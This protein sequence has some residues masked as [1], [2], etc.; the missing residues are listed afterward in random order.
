MTSFLLI[1]FGYLLGSIPTGVIV[2]RMASDV[3]LKNVG[4]GSTGATNV[5]R[6][7]GVKFGVI[8]MVG[9]CLKGLLPT[10]IARNFSNSPL[11]ITCVA[12]AALL[13]HIYPVYVGFRGG[14]G[15]ATS[16]GVLLGISPVVALLAFF[17]WGSTSKITGSITV[18][19]LSAA[20]ALPMLM[21]GIAS[22]MVYF[23]LSIVIFCLILFTHRDN[24]RRII[25]GQGFPSN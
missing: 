23:I 21:A 24:I 16:L 5:T 14:K 19:A 12:F 4:S 11:V 22:E 10:L 3:D 25:K 1:A 9:D 2:A 18:G 7:F 8:T 17:V 20:L 15:V 13:G 6:A